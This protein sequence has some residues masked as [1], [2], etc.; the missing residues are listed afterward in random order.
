MKKRP[1]IAIVQKSEAFGE[2]IANYQ[3]YPT[4]PVVPC[5]ANELHQS[6]L[7]PIRSTLD[8]YDLINAKYANDI[9]DASLI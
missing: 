2:E 4:F 8:C 9:D 3:N 5:W 6:E 1:Y 7:L